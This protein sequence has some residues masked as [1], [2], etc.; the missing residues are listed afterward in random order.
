RRRRQRDRV[1]LLGP[2]ERTRHRSDHHRRGW[3]RGPPPARP[4]DMSEVLAALRARTDAM[5]DDL[6]AIVR[7]ESPSNE[8]ESLQSCADVIEQIAGEYIGTPERIDVEGRRPLRWRHGATRV[9]LL[10]H[11]ATLSPRGTSERSDF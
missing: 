6:A 5:L 7:A 4:Q 11:Y 3:H 2:S 1:P 10:G 9:L 8:L